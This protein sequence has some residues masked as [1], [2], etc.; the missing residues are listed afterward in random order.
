M[1]QNVVII[2]FDSS[3]RPICSALLVLGDQLLDSLNVLLLS[4]LGLHVLDLGPLVVLGLA[5][6][7]S[8]DVSEA[9]RGI[10]LKG[11]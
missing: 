10:L 7:K 4:L 8:Y 9:C 5:L 2:S 6:Q 3:K 11:K 1:Y